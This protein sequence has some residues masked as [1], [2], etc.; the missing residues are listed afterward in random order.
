MHITN[1]W[2]GF[3]VRKWALLIEQNG[4]V[5]TVLMIGQPKGCITFFWLY[6]LIEDS[7]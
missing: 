2:L 3:V 6:G 5:N 1:N 7:I 4:I